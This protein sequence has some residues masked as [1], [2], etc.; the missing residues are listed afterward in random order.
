MVE[1][2]ITR[3]QR[4]LVNRGYKDTKTCLECGQVKPATLECVRGLLCGFCNRALGQVEK[5]MA[6]AMKYL[7][8]RERINHG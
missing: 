8:S 4:R 2:L 5:H 7:E 3:H 1:P 6:S